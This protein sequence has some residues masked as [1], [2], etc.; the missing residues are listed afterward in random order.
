M[1]RQA[2]IDFCN[3]IGQNQTLTLVIPNVRFVPI[4]LQKSAI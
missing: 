3:K 2:A 1:G 4:L